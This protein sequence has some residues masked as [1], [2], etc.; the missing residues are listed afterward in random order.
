MNKYDSSDPTADFTI[1]I[2]SIKF[3]G[4]SG[5]SGNSGNSSNSGNS[6]ML[7]GTVNTN[8]FTHS[9]LTLKIDDIYYYYVIAVNSSGESDYSDFKSIVIDKPQAPASVVA[10]AASDTKINLQWSSVTGAMEY[11]VYYSKSDNSSGSIKHNDTF[12][13]ASASLT[14]AEAKTTYYFWVKAKNPFGSS[15]FSPVGSAKTLGPPNDLV[16]TA[17]LSGS[18]GITAYLTGWTKTI[19]TYDQIIFLYAKDSPNNQKYYLGGFTVSS[20]AATNDYYLKTGF[21]LSGE[22]NTTY[23]IWAT[24]AVDDFGNSYAF[25]ANN[26]TFWKDSTGEYREMAESPYGYSPMV[27]VRTG[28]PPPPPP[29]TPPA[30]PPAA[31]STPP[32][33]G[34]T[35]EKMCSSCVGS[36]LC[37]HLHYGCAG[38]GKVDCTT[39]RG[40]LS[41]VDTKDCKTCNGSGS[42][43]CGKCNGSGKCSLCK[44]SGYR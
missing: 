43:K 27:E 30:P 19:Y 40:L 6:L 22:Y 1:V 33:G 34:G 16:I 11:E 28:S 13:S 37:N 44:G 26:N 15:D 20:F 21:H 32:S 29:P 4:S 7:A 35:N 3:Q 5:N 2:N 12:T 31:A 39:C 36:G 18:S 9:G 23:Y 17:K 14:G 41:K 8:S 10:K 24:K 25:M 42:I 38:S